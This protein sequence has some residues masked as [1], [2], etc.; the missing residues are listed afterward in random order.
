[1]QRPWRVFICLVAIAAVAPAGLVSAA[2]PSRTDS[3]YLVIDGRK[4]G[5]KDG[6]QVDTYQIELTSG[7]TDEVGMIFIDPSSTQGVVSPMATWGESYAISWEDWQWWYH[8]KAKAAANVYSGKRIIQVCIWYTRGGAVI[9]AK[10][11]SNAT[12]SNGY[13]VAGPEKRTE[14]TDT[15]D[16]FAPPTVFNFTTAR[17]NPDVS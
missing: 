13:W 1:M 8:G 17:I 7:S 12:N 2:S 5:P 6:L 4:F 10:V 16:P 9:S 14:C 11:C 15:L 3:P